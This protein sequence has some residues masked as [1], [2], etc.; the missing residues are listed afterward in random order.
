MGAFLDEWK[1]IKTNFEGNTGGKKPRAGIF[2][3]ASGLEKAATTLD[4]ALD[5]TS[6]SAA[7][8]ARAGFVSS[9]NAY[10]KV[11][12]KKAAETHDLALRAELQV[13]YGELDLLEKKAERAVDVH[14]E[15]IQEVDLRYRAWELV[16]T[17]LCATTLLKSD[18]A[19]RFVTRPEFGRDFVTG[20]PSPDMEDAREKLRANLVAYG[21]K[22]ALLKKFKPRSGPLAR[23]HFRAFLGLLHDAGDE[24]SLINGAVGALG[25]WRLVLDAPLKANR[26]AGQ[27]FA[28]SAVKQ[29]V[30]L[31]NEQLSA[32]NERMAKLEQT[33]ERQVEKSR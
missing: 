32:E 16:Q 17:E 11:L 12:A 29:V 21:Q 33:F 8:K 2:S 25:A 5:G 30:D 28:Q 4:K 24:L 23:D 31:L 9:S 7:V 15:A 1:Q 6:A 27:R 22:L 18:A 19:K 20:A 14:V 26:N 10:Q 3:T 13:M